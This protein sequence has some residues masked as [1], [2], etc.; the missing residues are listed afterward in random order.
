MFPIID[1]PSISLRPLGALYIELE[2]KNKKR[3]YNNT[4]K[5]YN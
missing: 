1:N 3:K 5:Q 4:G 2:A